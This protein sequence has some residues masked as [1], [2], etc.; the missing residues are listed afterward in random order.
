MARIATLIVAL[1]TFVSTSGSFSGAVSPAWQERQGAFRLG[2][3]LVSLSVTVR[4]TARQYVEDLTRDDFHVYEN[5]VPQQ[6]TFF[7]KSNIPLGVAICLDSS[8]SMEQAMPIAQE[9]AIRFARTL[10][11]AD[12]ATVIDF[13][14]TAKTAQSFT[15]DVDAIETAIRGT[16]A[17]GSTALFN[18]LYVALNQLNKLPVQDE[19]RV[20]RRRAIVLLSDGADTSSLVD[21]QEVLDVASRSDTAIYSIGLGPRETARP[22]TAEEGDFVLRR[23]AEQTGGRAFFPKEAREL[24]DVYAD[25]R[26]ELTRQYALAYESTGGARNGEWR[27]ISVRVDRP[28]VLV[29]TRQGYFAP[30]R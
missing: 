24:A 13:D 19:H 8:A 16:T 27:R 15:N 23:L 12:L 3:E 4:N 11:S 21:F 9:A 17:G 18:A 29:R 26:E 2:V 20:P 7:G 1:T 5:G 14:S 22:A 10:R 30:G 6:L 25:I 28:N